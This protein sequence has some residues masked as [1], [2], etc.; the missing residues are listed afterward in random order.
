MDEERAIISKILSVGSPLSDW[1]VKVHCGVGAGYRNAFVV[2]D[3]S[4][5]AKYAHAVLN[6]TLVCAACAVRR[7]LRSIL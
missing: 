7:M 4:E 2:E 3:A 6:S 5:Y 1:N